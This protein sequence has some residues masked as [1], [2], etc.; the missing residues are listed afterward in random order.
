M[1]HFKKILIFLC[2]QAFILSVS[3]C[4]SVTSEAGTTSGESVQSAEE[5]AAAPARALVVYFSC[6]GTTETAAKHAAKAIGADL[7]QI[8]PEVPY[9]PEDLDYGD[10]SSR[11]NAEQNHDKARPGIAGI[12]ENME[13]YE[14]IFL[15]YP[16]WWGQAPKIVSTF[17]ESYDLSG[18]TI[19]PFCTSG[20]SGIG[21]SAENLRSLCPDTVIWLEGRRFGGNASQAEIEQWVAELDLSK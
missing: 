10:D 3:A 14:T 12:V 17:V 13:Q 9:T 5:T 11:A 8:V 7:Y 2:V 15:G 4:Q 18:K 20:S 21:S 16:I 1:R 19:V 6:T